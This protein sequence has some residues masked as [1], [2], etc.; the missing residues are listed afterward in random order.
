MIPPATAASERVSVM[1]WAVEAAAHYIENARQRFGCADYPAALSA[2]ERGGR[3]KSVE[4]NAR[5]VGYRDVLKLP[6]ELGARLIDCVRDL[7]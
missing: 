1:G 5:F 4:S 6:T 2:T 7:A 3:T